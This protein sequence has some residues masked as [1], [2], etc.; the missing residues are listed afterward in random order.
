MDVLGPPDAGIGCGPV[1]SPELV[2]RHARDSRPEGLGGLEIEAQVEIDPNAQ[3]RL[4]DREEATEP[5]K[6]EAHHLRLAVCEAHHSVAFR[7]LPRVERDAGYQ[8]GLLVEATDAL[9][10]CPIELLDLAELPLV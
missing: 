3:P 4:V 8:K 9:D 10:T 7:T 2:A 6:K 1:G 5:R